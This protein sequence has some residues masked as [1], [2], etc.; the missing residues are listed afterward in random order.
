MKPQVQHVTPP[1]FIRL[2]KSGERCPHTGLSRT[3]L[4]ELIV[5][6]KRNGFR[7]PVKSKHHKQ[8]NAMRGIRIIYYPSL[9][10]YLTNQET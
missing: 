8:P 5:P 4:F 2:P 1:D 9:V 7:P 6:C 3:T 10:S